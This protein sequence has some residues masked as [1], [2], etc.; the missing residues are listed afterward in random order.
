VN[1]W[2]EYQKERATYQT[3][4]DFAWALFKERGYLLQGEFICQKCGLRKDSDHPKG[5]F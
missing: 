5:D 3:V 2:D 4:E 1:R